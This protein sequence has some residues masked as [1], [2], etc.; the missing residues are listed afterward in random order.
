[1]LR[2]ADLS[3]HGVM[4]VLCA[5]VPHTMVWH[6][7]SQAGVWATIELTSPT[8]R[9]LCVHGSWQRKP[10]QPRGTYHIG[11]EVATANGASHVVHE[12]R[13]AN[14]DVAAQMLDGAPIVGRLHNG[15]IVKGYRK[16]MSM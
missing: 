4:S 13:V 3:E 2:M 10:G 11:A 14:R 8:G 5:R 9:R 6:G 15:G 16:Q 1:M 12:G 7:A